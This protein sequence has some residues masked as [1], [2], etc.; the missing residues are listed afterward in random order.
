MPRALYLSTHGAARKSS[1]DAP[2]IA[3]LAGKRRNQYKQ[4]TALSKLLHSFSREHPY[5]IRFERFLVDAFR[6]RSGGEKKRKRA[7]AL[8]VIHTL[9][10]A[11]EVR[12]AD[13][14]QRLQ[15]D[16]SR[17]TDDEIDDMIRRLHRTRLIRSQQ[18]PHARV[19]I[20]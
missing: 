3:D 15:A 1:S 14:V 19:H 5:T 16:T 18:G 12:R 17:Y 2:I 9:D 13:I 8:K 7:L 6:N 11:Q 4:E 20:A 10:G